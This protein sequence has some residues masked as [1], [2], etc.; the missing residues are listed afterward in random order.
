MR[1]QQNSVDSVLVSDC[2]GKSPIR[3]LP[4]HAKNKG[5]GSRRTTEAFQ[6]QSFNPP[7]YVPCDQEERYFCCSWVKLSMRMPMEPSFSLATQ[8]STSTGTS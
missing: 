1:V 7:N 2:S 6:K 8:F 3:R 5:S 4:Y